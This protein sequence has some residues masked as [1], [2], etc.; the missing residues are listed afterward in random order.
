MAVEHASREEL[1]VPEPWSVAEDRVYGETTLT[2]LRL[3]AGFAGP[4]LSAAEAGALS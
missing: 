3:E 2:F 1:V 4:N